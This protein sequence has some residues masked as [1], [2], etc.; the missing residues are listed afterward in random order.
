MHRKGKQLWLV[1]SKN[2]VVSSLIECESYKKDMR[3]LAV[4]LGMKGQWMLRPGLD[5]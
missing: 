1:L 3:V 5:D 4:H 2:G